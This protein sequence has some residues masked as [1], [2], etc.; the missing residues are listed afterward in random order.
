MVYRAKYTC[1][2]RQAGPVAQRWELGG[3]P[4]QAVPWGPYQPGGFK[5][6]EELMTIF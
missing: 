1:G 2:R 6:G 4:Q 5:W 3:E